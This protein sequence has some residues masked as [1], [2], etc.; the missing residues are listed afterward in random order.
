MEW[1]DTKFTAPVVANPRYVV[2]G[3]PFGEVGRSKCPQLRKSVAGIT[4]DSSLANVWCD[5]PFSFRGEHNEVSPV[6]V[7]L[8]L[9]SLLVL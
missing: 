9:F 2:V 4:W 6:L 3:I 7:V 1:C 5:V 8:C